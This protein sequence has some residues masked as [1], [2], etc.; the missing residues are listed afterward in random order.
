MRPTPYVASLRVYEPISAFEP[1][2][3]LRWQ[4]LD[5]NLATG[6]EEQMRALM[7]TV[8]IEPPALAADGA[9]VM[10]FEGLRYVAP[11]STSTRCLVAL[12]RFKQSLPA[13]LAQ[14]FLPPNIEDAIT[15]NSE[16]IEDRIPH[17]LTE[18]WLVPP[19]WF[20][21][22]TSDDRL[23][24][25]NSDGPFVIHRTSIANAKKRGQFMHQAVVNAFGNGPIEGEIE[26]MVNW[27]GLFH[28]DSIVEL[29]YGGLAGYL[30]LT[31][32]ELGGLEADNSVE[33][34]NE[35]LAGL[36]AGDPQ[37]AGR[38][39]ESLVGRWRKVAALEQA[40]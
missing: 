5:I 20:G 38:G 40:N 7:R 26:D 36:A 4:A 14:Y 33:D 3:Q 34:L 22:F 30:E 32:A 1:A 8:F 17:I 16:V 37:V 12:D 23:R 35:S 29:D 10:D 21:L 18:T 25:R 39:Y 28:P 6:R 2:E 27:L 24:G 31:L 19:R 9:H 15:I 13:T 11:W